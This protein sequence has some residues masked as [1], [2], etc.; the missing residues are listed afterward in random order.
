M[1][2]TIGN[3]EEFRRWSHSGIFSAAVLIGDEAVRLIALL[4]VIGTAMK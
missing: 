4:N 2:Q 1:I 3:V